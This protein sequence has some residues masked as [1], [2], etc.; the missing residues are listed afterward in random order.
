MKVSLKWAEGY[1]RFGAFQKWLGP[2]RHTMILETFEMKNG[3]S[4][5]YIHKDQD[6]QEYA[7][8]GVFHEV[9][10]PERII[11]TFNQHVKPSFQWPMV[12]NS[13]SVLNSANSSIHINAIGNLL[14]LMDLILGDRLHPEI[15]FCCRVEYRS[16][17]MET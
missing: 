9:V 12:D 17:A 7:F 13:T 8:H 10:A 4:W 5:R 11:Q 16:A 3:G 6:G 1:H 14:T 15:L 2:C